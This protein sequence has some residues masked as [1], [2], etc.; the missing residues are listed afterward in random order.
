MSNGQADRLFFVHI[1]KTGGATFRQHL[2]RTFEHG[3][4][5]PVPKQDDMQRAWL[6]DELL[7][8]PAD[9]RRRI[10]VYTGHFPFVVTE[11]IGME[12]FTL[13][14]LRDPVERTISYLKHCKRYH[15]QHRDLELHE[16]YDDPFYYSCFVHNHQSKIFAMT[17]EDRL[18]SYMDIVDI[19][20]RRLEIAKGNLEK[21]DIVGLS[22]RYSDFLED[23]SDQL[24]LHLQ[25][26]GN[27]RVSRE[28]WDVQPW[29]RE[30]IA[31]DNAADV[32][33]Y[34]FGSQLQENRRRAAVDT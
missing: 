7:H 25:K 8:L 9:R 24:G 26:V 6:V 5:Y 34:E 32:A 31:E 15:D 14:I 1:M 30:R 17:A 18:E 20:D 33:F 22:E 12:L 11:L 21:V 2:Y 3:E 10:R 29:L 19:D 28:G 23:V 4:V 13:T 27:R 16:I